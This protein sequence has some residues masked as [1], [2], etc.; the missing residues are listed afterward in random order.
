MVFWFIAHHAPCFFS[1]SGGH[2]LSSQGL[3]LLQTLQNTGAFF[4]LDQ[5]G[6]VV[7]EGARQGIRVP[8]LE[9]NQIPRRIVMVFGNA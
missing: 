8:R 2:Q 1:S 4:F 7:L 6:G 9:E 5:L 3:E